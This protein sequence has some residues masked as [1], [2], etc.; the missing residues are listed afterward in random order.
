MFRTMKA[1]LAAAALTV[2]VTVAGPAL[3]AGPLA[4]TTDFP[5]GVFNGDPFKADLAGIG[6]GVELAAPTAIDVLSSA[7]LTFKLLAAAAPPRG[8]FAIDTLV[9]NGVDYEFGAQ[10]FTFPGTV[11]GS[12]L[13]SGSFA[14]QVGFR[15]SDMPDD[16][17]IFWPDGFQVYI[18][19]ADEPN[20]SGIGPFIGNFDT[21]YFSIG[22][23]ALFEV[24]SVT[25]GVPEPATWGL[26]IL[27]FGLAGAGLRRRRLALA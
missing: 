13:F 6:V 16:A 12:Q 26:M 14:S 2:S 5:T 23:E 17:T 22:G 1:T 25:G 20:L 27:G 19:S 8:G 4:V 3:A 15:T 21:L 9:V 24:T 18:R 7:N 11:L 10:G